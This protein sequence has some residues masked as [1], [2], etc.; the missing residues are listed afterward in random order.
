[1][2]RVTMSMTAQ[3]ISPTARV[4][5]LIMIIMTTKFGQTSRRGAFASPAARGNQYRINGIR[6]LQLRGA[7]GL[8]IAKSSTVRPFPEPLM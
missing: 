5:Y 4:K 3:H 7:P 8:S 1:M 6:W 2:L